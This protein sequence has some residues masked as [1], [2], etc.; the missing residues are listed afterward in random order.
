MAVAG[1]K[2]MVTLLELGLLWCLNHPRAALGTWCVAGRKVRPRW[3]LCNRI[4]GD[5][6]SLGVHH[7]CLREHDLI[8]SLFLPLSRFVSCFSSVQVQLVLQKIKKLMPCYWYTRWFAHKTTQAISSARSGVIS[9]HPEGKVCLES[10]H[11]LRLRTVST[12]DALSQAASVVWHKTT[13]RA[14]FCLDK[15]LFAPLEIKVNV[16]TG[17]F[18]ASWV[19]FTT[20]VSELEGLA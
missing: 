20:C 4:L 15:I 3:K 10:Q 2:R 17:T 14:H 5:S 7:A 8:L 13:A 19:C 9:H 1:N 16:I 11:I 6:I 12:K 18:P